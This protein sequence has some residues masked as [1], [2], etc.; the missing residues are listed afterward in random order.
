MNLQDEIASVESDMEIYRSNIAFGDA[1]KRLRSNKDFKKVI[2]QTYLT[3]NALR[4]VELLSDP[5]N[6]S[7]AKENAIIVELKSIGT[8]KSFFR[9]IDKNAEDAAMNLEKAQESMEFLSEQLDKENE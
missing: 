4:L 9:F 5:A 8:L 7:D 1:L 3:D 6:D 2:E